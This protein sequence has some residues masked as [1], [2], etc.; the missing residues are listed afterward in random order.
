VNR[1][2]QCARL[3]LKASVANAVA[4][5][6][7]YLELAG[8]RF[9]VRP[10]Q[11]QVSRDM[12][13]GSRLTAEGVRALKKEGYRAIVSLTAERMKGEERAAAELGLRHFYI[14]IVDNTAP[15][16]DQ[17]TRFLELTQDPANQPVYVHCE[18]G[19]GRTGVAVAVRRMAVDGWPMGRA[20]AEARAYGLRLRSQ[21]DFLKSFAHLLAGGQLP[22]YP[23]STAASRSATPR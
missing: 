20:I 19:K 2:L 13:R 1:T 9:P 15:T 22:G 3:Q 7:G 18:A 4:P 12:R 11:A 5:L 17:M 16:I 23:A 8:I 10:Y 14:P 6:V 21:K